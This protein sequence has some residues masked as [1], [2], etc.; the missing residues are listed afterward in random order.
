MKFGT[1][2]I[3]GYDMVD[4]NTGA[5]SIPICQASTF[6]Q[7]D[8]DQ[9]QQYTYSRF[10][11]PTRDA[12]EKAIASLEQTKYALAFSSGMAA[13]TSVLLSFAKGDHIVM[14]KDVYGGTFQLATEIFPRFGIEVSFIDE[15]NLNEWEKAIKANTKAF[16]IE[17]PSNPTLKITDIKGVCDIAKKH[18][19]KTIID[20]TFM[21]PQYLNATSLGVDIIIHSAT[22][23]LNGHSDVIMGIVAFNCDNLYTILKKQQIVF[24]A[25]P[26]I[27]E[28]W[29]LMR[30]LKT[31]KIR[32]DQSVKTAM[33]IAEFLQN[34]KAVKKVYYPGLK[35]H[36]GYDIHNKQ[37]SSGGAVLSFELENCEAVKEVFCNVKIPIIAVSLGGVESILSY[38]WKMSHACMPE[39]ERI[40][41]GVTSGL[42]R[43]S[44]GIEDT[45]D[46]IEDLEQAMK[47]LKAVK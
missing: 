8:I 13:I 30:G 37:C 46:L 9:N 2:I 31:M 45:E 23:F 39:E 18:N 22:K 16:Y 36:V 17:T 11:N 25:L 34:H 15:T 32:M 3:H 33:K 6:H 5:S 20:A 28:C 47:N 19:I 44:V 1:K 24:G 14:C 27:D 35:T 38:P 4:K 42:I 29:L 7:C 10:G 21:T 12:V 26:G 43:F 40:K 41:Q